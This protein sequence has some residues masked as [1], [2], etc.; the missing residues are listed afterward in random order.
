MWECLSCPI[1][2]NPVLAFFNYLLVDRSGFEPTSIWLHPGLWTTMTCDLYQLPG[3]GACAAAVQSLSCREESLAS[4]WSGKGSQVRGRAVIHL[5]TLPVHCLP[6]WLQFSAKPSAFLYHRLLILLFQYKW[7]TGNCYSSDC[8][9]CCR[10]QI[11]LIY[12]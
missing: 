10:N 5:L 12:S 11:A 7:F 9:A 1:P 2:E 4:G 8:W 3:N 6:T